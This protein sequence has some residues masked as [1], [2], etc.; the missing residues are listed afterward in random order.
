MPEVLSE[1]FELVPRDSVRPHPRNPRQGDLGALTE[2][3][4]LN[5]FYGALV[6]QSSTGYILAGNHR[7]RAAEM[8]GLEQ[9]PVIWVDVDEDA[10]NRILL[11]DNRLNDLADYDGQQLVDLLQELVM[12]DRGLE[13][14]GYDGDDLDELMKDLGLLNNGA[15]PPGGGQSKEVVC[16]ECG[17]VFTP[18]RDA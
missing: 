4:R 1:Q 17:H 18:G 15:E 3:I 10:A 7:W 14:T 13:G 9:V 12:S 11:V 6:V 5:G 8:L 16:P 2:S